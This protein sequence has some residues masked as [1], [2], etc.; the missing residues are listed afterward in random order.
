MLNDYSTKWLHI[1]DHGCF[2]Q[3]GLEMAKHWGRVTYSTFW[4]KDFPLSYDRMF[5]YGLEN[6]WAHG[7][8][9]TRCDD[10]WEIRHKVDTWWAPDL[11][12][13]GV[14]TVL[15]DDLKKDVLPF[16]FRVL[17]SVEMKF[18]YPY[19][20]KSSDIALLKSVAS[21]GNFDHFPHVPR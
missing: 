4:E 5:G 18:L 9:V 16:S 2:I 20:F 21:D 11:Y 7:I 13:A 6:Y 1:L 12:Y 3:A 14:A 19:P 17:I 15:R 8:G 10:P